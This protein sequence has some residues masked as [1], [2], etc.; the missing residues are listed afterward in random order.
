MR[1]LNL[2]LITTP[3]KITVRGKLD[4][5]GYGQD[6]GGRNEVRFSAVRAERLD[7]FASAN[8]YLLNTLE[9]YK[10]AM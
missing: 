10:A 3:F 8:Q 2:R 9:L 5:S 4:T 1:A 7:S 6:E